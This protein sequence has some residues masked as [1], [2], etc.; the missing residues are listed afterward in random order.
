MVSS[1]L[2]FFDGDHAIYVSARHKALHD[3]RVAGDIA[4]LVSSKDDVILDFGCGEATEA[5]IVAARCRRLYLSDAAPAVLSRVAERY[6]QRPDVTVATPAEVED[7]PAGSLD[8][9]VVNSLSQYLPREELTRW[10][11]IW[12][13]LLKPGGRLVLGDVIPPSVSPLTDATALLRFG[14]EGGFL[15][16]ALGGLVRTALSDYRTLRAQLGLSTYTEPEI[17]GLVGAAGLTPAR[18]RPNIGHNQAR[19]TIVGTKP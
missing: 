5:G 11:R 6:A 17:L 12:A 2:D 19:M 7:L 16:A 9:I 8:L 10:L 18:H 4:A 3:R 14:W 15:L 1:W 13:G